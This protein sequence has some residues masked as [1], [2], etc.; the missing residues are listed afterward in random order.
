MQSACAFQ[1][2]H[3]SAIRT[4]IHAFKMLENSFE[5]TQKDDTITVIKYLRKFFR[6]KMF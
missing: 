2:I 4:E 5:K 1:Q 6:T 3:K